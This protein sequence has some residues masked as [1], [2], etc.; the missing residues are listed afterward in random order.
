MSSVDVPVTPS[1][2]VT[3]GEPLEGPHVSMAIPDIGEGSKTQE[4]GQER[5]LSAFYSWYNPALGGPNCARFINGVCVSRMASGLR[6]QDWMGATPGAVACPP[7]FPFWTEIIFEGQRWYCLDRGGAIKTVDGIPWL[8]FLVT[9][10]HA[11]FGELV[12]VEVIWP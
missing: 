12:T 3:P 11:G 8:D 2:T 6:W 1:A 4:N 10:P 7:E 9:V 5:A